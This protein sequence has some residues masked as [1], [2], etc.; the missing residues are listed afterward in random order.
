MS[1]C[2][3][4]H[5]AGQP[6][7]RVKIISYMKIDVLILSALQVDF[8]FTDYQVGRW[9][10]QALFI[11]FSFVSLWLFDSK[12]MLSYSLVYAQVAA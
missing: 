8:S 10:F 7:I 12:Y 5:I 2:Y 9:C 11:V 3:C 4:F 6:K 1:I